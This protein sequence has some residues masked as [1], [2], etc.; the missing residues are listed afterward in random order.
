MHAMAAGMLDREAEYGPFDSTRLSAM[1]HYIGLLSG[2]RLPGITAPV[3]FVRPEEA[4][5]TSGPWTAGDSVQ[6]PGDHFG[7]V[8]EHAAATADAVE[9]WLTSVTHRD[10]EEKH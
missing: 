5:G 9:K 6:V 4:A 2:L 3:L 7:I 1:A 10:G 8:E